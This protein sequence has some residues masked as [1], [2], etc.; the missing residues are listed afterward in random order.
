MSAIPGYNFK[1]KNSEGVWV[2]IPILYMTLY[3]AYVS[4]CTAHSIVNIV[5]QETYYETLGNLQLLTDQLAGSAD[6]LAGLS[7]ALG[8]GVLPQALG[9]TGKIIT[10]DEYV[11]ILLQTE[12]ADFTSAFGNYYKDVENVKTVLASAEAW[13]EDTYY[14]RQARDYATF[15]AFLQALNVAFEE[16][17]GNLRGDMFDAF[18][19]PKLN[20]AD[21]GYGTTEP[22]S[23]DPKYYFQ[24]DA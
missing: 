12:P 10:D 22:G 5:S 14:K 20:V 19:E 7:S 15:T 18:D 21:I 6:A 1:Y 11:Y 17:L 2:T 9:G 24:Y 13:A 16:D 23:G 3:D 4:Y 8:S